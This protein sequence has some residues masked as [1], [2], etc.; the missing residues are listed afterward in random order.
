MAESGEVARA[1][2]GATLFDVARTR[3]SATLL[4]V[5][6]LR[7]G[8]TLLEV[9]RLSGWTSSGEMISPS[10]DPEEGANR[11]EVRRDRAAIEGHRRD[12]ASRAMVR[13]GLAA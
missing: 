11:M 4:E 9:A 13:Q 12:R 10:G 1:S 3:G 8:S 6:R 5:A 2:C 7:D